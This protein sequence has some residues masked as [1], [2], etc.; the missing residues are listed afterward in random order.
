MEELR[1]PLPPDDPAAKMA[2]ALGAPLLDPAQA[3]ALANQELNYTDGFHLTSGS[4]RIIAL[5]LADLAKPYLA[6][7]N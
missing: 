5:S 1:D 6:S 4:A 2:K 7:G 3:T